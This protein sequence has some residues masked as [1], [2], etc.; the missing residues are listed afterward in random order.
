MEGSEPRVGMSISDLEEYH[1]PGPTA[2]LGR[3]QWEGVLCY[4]LL[5]RYP[6]AIG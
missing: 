1:V 5:K 6:I 3:V 4:I 2:R